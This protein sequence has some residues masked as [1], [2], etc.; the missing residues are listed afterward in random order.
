[1]FPVGAIFVPF[2]PKTGTKLLH[3]RPPPPIVE[4]IP[5]TYSGLNE[6]M[7]AAE[8]IGRNPVSIHQIQPE[9]EE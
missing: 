8:E 7:G 3:P 6:E 4:R 2:P 1:M 5:M 9:Y